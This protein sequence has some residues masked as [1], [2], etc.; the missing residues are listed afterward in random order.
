MVGIKMSEKI[1]KVT[2]IIFEKLTYYRLKVNN[3]NLELM[4]GVKTT[5]KP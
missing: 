2:A 3:T 5:K 1:T 4:R